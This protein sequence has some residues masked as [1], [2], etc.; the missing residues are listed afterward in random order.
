MVITTPSGLSTGSLG[1]PVIWTHS[2][3]P[4][5]LQV[6]GSVF[7]ALYRPAGANSFSTGGE[8]SLPRVVGYGVAVLRE[9]F[10]SG[11][12]GFETEFLREVRVLQHRVQLSRPNSVP[13]SG[14]VA[15][16]AGASRPKNETVCFDYLKG[17]CKG[18]CG[19]SHRKP[20][21]EELAKLKKLF[22]KL[23]S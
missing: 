16:R 19:R 1:I 8:A 18:G 4:R 17:T 21:P 5:P 14:S 10:L 6:G 2:T 15:A 3:L 13:S 22:P 12:I 9:R 11:P 7:P 23:V 20:P